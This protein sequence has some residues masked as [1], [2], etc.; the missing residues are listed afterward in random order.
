MVACVTASLSSSRSTNETTCFRGTLCNGGTL[1]VIPGNT[2]I[3][4]GTIN[5]LINVTCKHISNMDETTSGSLNAVCIL[6]EQRGQRC[7]KHC[8]VVSLCTAQIM[9]FK[10]GKCGGG[11]T[12]ATM[13]LCKCMWCFLGLWVSHSFQTS[14]A[15]WGIERSKCL[16]HLE[17]AASI[18]CGCSASC[19]EHFRTSSILAKHL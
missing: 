7:L 3:K 9:E 18:K 13:D 19:S 16:K 8:A 5:L 12:P 4:Q 14:G 2:V 15:S 6:W 11:F 10:Q 1:G 17:S